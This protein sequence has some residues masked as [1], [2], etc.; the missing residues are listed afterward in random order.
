[1]KVQ[2][3]TSVPLITLAALLSGCSLVPEYQRPQAPVPAQFAN[4]ST[5][6]SQS[7]SAVLDWQGILRDH[8]LQQVVAMALN[9]NRDLRVAL[10]NIEKARAQY[11]IEDSAL[12][13]SV[14]AGLTHTASKPVVLLLVAMP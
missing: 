13:P 10:L 11:R 2:K 6:A 4:T 9:N 3:L 8:R 12:Y 1:M 14:T 5:N 7:S